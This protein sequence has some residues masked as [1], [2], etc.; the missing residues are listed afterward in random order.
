MKCD[1][2]FQFCSIKQVPVCKRR[3]SCVKSRDEQTSPVSAV[4]IGRKLLSE[5]R[6]DKRQNGSC[7]CCSGWWC[8]GSDHCGQVTT[9][10]TSC[11][12]QDHF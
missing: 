5:V 8:G 11:L 10:D 7:S 2:Y 6:Q 12:S 4:T 9:T 1:S 3:R